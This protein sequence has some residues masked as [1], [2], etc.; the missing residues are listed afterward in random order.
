MK[1]ALKATGSLLLMALI[2]VGSSL[3][4]RPS[5]VS[6][7]AIGKTTSP[8]HPSTYTLAQ[9]LSTCSRRGG[10]SFALTPLVMKRFG[11]ASFGCIEAMANASPAMVL[12]LGL[13][14]DVAALPPP[15]LAQLRKGQVNLDDPA[16]TLTLLQRNAVLGVTGFFRGTS[17]QSM[18]IQC[19]LCHS[20]VDPSFRAPGIPPGTI[21]R[22]LD[23]WANRDLNVGAIMALAPN[24]TP[25]TRLLQIV[26]PSL[27]DR[28]VRAVLHRWGPGKFDAA[29]LLDGKTMHPT[30]GM[31]AATLIP[32]VFRLA[33]VNNHTWTGAWGSVP[34]WNA[35]VANL[36]M[37]GQ[38]TFFDRA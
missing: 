21:G 3:I 31:S 32:P 4:G 19:A 1:G 35:F 16:V 36:E 38:G 2:G 8:L 6:R 33:G 7:L 11:V 12:A 20:T 29:L 18:G 13:K 27:T 37:H 17:L 23:G 30:T 9:T 24:I 26:D 25:V 15:L 14:V 10:T 5:S 34:Y 22:R 28:Q